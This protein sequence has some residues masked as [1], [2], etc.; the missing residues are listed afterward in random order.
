[1]FRDKIDQSFDRILH[2]YE[3]NVI[4]V[5]RNHIVSF[6]TP[7]S[8]QNFEINL[9]VLLNQSLDKML[10]KISKEKVNQG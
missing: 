10:P 3:K 9:K 5:R 1:M 7:W 6:F 4:K 8:R 2:S